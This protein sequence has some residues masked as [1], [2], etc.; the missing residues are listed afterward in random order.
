[1][2]KIWKGAIISILLCGI[3]FYVF[4][5]YK[6][7][8]SYR[9]TRIPE[10]TTSLIR[11]DVY[12]I[13]KSMLPD[14]FG[15]KKREG[16]PMFEGLVI[17]AN[18]FVYTVKG[19]QP[20]TLF[21]SLQ[22]DDAG[23]FETSL[24]KQKNL[25]PEPAKIPGIAVWMSPDKSW[26]IAFNQERVVVAY[27]AKKE[28]VL[29]ILSDILLDKNTI[30]IAKSKFK[31]IKKQ[32]GHLTY[33]SGANSGHLEFNKGN[34][35]ASLTIAGIGKAVLPSVQHQQPDSHN[36]INL[37]LYADMSP[38]L[39]QKNFT[40]DTI[41]I[42]GDSLLASH[43][44]GIEMALSQPVLQ[45]DS[46]VTYEYNDDFE[47]VA[48][49]TVNETAVPGIFIRAAADAIL[50][51]AYLQRQGI[52]GYDSGLV[53]K[54]IVPLYQL[55]STQTKE[56]LQWSTVKGSAVSN[57]LSTSNTFF[58]LKIDFGRLAQQP[59]F[60]LIHRYLK[61]FKNLDAKG[62]KAKNNE[63]QFDAILYF[64]ED[65]RQALWQ[66]MDIL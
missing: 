56:Y 15:R 30:S 53:S 3:G 54:R 10:N 18:I 60:S 41:T 40:I 9:T 29:D 45:K 24:K 1:M 6:Q 44:K 39:H 37:W 38:W 43:P 47:K 11:V 25:V 32:E 55:Y 52:I 21:S 14:Y 19:K 7:H 26:A 13:Y 61:P 49:V 31:T 50:L 22:L 8:S 64:K 20:T 36:I 57:T 58:G 2:R 62:T 34:I 35:T 65:K 48:T 51:Q 5:I 59:E 42:C 27:S 28:P 46:V 12:R 16:T 17:P 63:V 33:L 66:L 4:V 23:A